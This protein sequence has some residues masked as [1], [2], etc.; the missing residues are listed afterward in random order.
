MK[1]QFNKRKFSSRPGRDGDRKKEYS[2]KPQWKSGEN[3]ERR[4]DSGRPE[5]KKDTRGGGERDQRS[6][7]TGERRS[8]GDR[9]KRFGSKPDWKKDSHSKDDRGQRSGGYGERRS[10]GDKE[11]R[12]GSKPDWKKD[13]HS[14]DDRGQR[15]GGYGERRNDGDK[16]KRFSSKPDW[17]K[18]SRSRDDRSQRSGGYS[19][20]RNDGD[21]KKGFDSKPDWK[22]DTHSKDERRP[23]G[24]R[25]GERRNDGDKEKRFDKK[26][27]WKKD[28]SKRTGGYERKHTEGQGSEIPWEKR[29]SWS[30]Y[31]GGSRGGRFGRKP[32]D[33]TRDQNLKKAFD[34]SEKSALNAPT[35]IAPAGPG[36][37]RLN[38]YL[39]NAGI[40][41]RREADKFIAAGVV[42]VNGKIVTELG[43]KVSPSDKVQFG[44]NKV[45]KEKTV[46]ILMNKPKGYITTCDDPNERDTVMDLIKEIPE[47][48]YPVGRLD[49]NTSGLLL[50]TNDGELAKILMHPKYQIPKVYHVELDKPLR[51]DDM[52]KIR[53]GFELEDGFIKP[54]D[55]AYVD[56]AASKKEVGIEIHS[57]RNR[58]V[59]RIFESLGYIVMKLDRVFYAGLTKKTLSRGK[60]RFLA[61]NEVRMLKR[62]K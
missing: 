21:R 58:I 1:K 34:R 51:A 10:D 28:D 40:C 53:E 54:D 11:K 23:Q 9:K 41:S 3:A 2:G 20:R 27:E 19:E 48:V 15:S 14:K 46:Y 29:K 7:G 8:D 5:W 49:R 4:N 37:I 16:K 32:Y 45:H 13:S 17:K 26:P 55:I 44:G 57:G 36:L 31:S 12:F 59:R 38:K 22:K 30:S 6:E 35:T 33:K 61:E 25:Y 42:T 56:G 60:W 18:D 47:R 24:S 39:S 50:L 52:E 43:H 62:T